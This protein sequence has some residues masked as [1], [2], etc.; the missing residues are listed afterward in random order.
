[1]FIIT[2]VEALLNRVSFMLLMRCVRIEYTSSLSSYSRFDS[3]YRSWLA[4]W[5][6]LRIATS[7]SAV[8][9]VVSVGSQDDSVVDY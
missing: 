3:I 1:M 2:K 5:L 9:S 8:R 4:F 7:T 6:I